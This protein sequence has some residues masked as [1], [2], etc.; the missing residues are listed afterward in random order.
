MKRNHCS[1]YLLRKLKVPDIILYWPELKS[2]LEE[3][4]I[5]DN[6]DTQAT[7]L[8]LT[9]Q[10]RSYN[11]G[12]I[13]TST[14]LKGHTTERTDWPDIIIPSHNG[15][16]LNDLVRERVSNDINRLFKTNLNR[17]RISIASKRIIVGVNVGNLVEQIAPL[18]GIKIKPC[19]RYLNSHPLR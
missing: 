1:L 11:S 19:P 4:N 10:Q 15:H 16:S 7:T 5:H 14:I 8:V 9:G 18:Y 12:R 2:L 17:N 13:Y 3:N 6:F